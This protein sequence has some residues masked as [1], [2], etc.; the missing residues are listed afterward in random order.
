MLVPIGRFSVLSLVLLIICSLLQRRMVALRSRLTWRP[1]G[2]TSLYQDV[3]DSKVD[4]LKALRKRAKFEHRDNIAA[5]LNNIFD[6]SELTLKTGMLIINVYK[7][8]GQ[9]EEACDVIE[10]L[11]QQ[12]IM[13]DVG[14]YNNILDGCAQQSNYTLAEGLL[15]LMID[16][17]VRRDTRSYTSAISAF[18][19]AGH[20]EKAFELLEI[21]MHQDNVVPDTICYSAVITACANEGRITDALRLLLQMK[22]RDVPIDL[23]IYNSV[24]SA[25]SKAGNIKVA[26]QLLYHMYR[27]NIPRDIYVRNLKIYI[28]K[29]ISLSFNCKINLSD[30]YIRNSCL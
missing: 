18:S 4:D 23:I 5:Q 15:Q 28:S 6:R 21:V 11:I 1:I 9:L 19:K 30:I 16:R 10:K 7:E 20:W 14:I 26:L 13:P 25:C 12:G 29:C 27:M 3:V 22:E 24:I 8:L 17:G 2:R